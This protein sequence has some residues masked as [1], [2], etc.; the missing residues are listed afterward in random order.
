M[1]VSCRRGDGLGEERG[2]CGDTLGAVEGESGCRGDDEINCRR[3]ADGEFSS[4]PSFRGEARDGLLCFGGE[5]C[6]VR[7]QPLSSPAHDRT[8]IQK[9]YC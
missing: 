8:K 4:K 3:V 7:L 1:G 5:P 9:K 6:P 2:L